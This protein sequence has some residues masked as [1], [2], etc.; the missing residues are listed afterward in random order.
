[1]VEPHRQDLTGGFF[2]QDFDVWARY[3][4]LMSPYWERF[5]ELLASG[6]YL[7]ILEP[8]FFAPLT[9]LRSVISN[10]KRT[11]AYVIK[12]R[13]PHLT[14][15][16]TCD[17]LLLRTAVKPSTDMI[18]MLATRLPELGYRCALAISATSL[19]ILNPIDPAT[20]TNVA[21]Y[22]SWMHYGLGKR[23]ALFTII[24]SAGLFLFLLVRSMLKDRQVLARILSDPFTAWELIFISSH[25][26]HAFEMMLNQMRPRLVVV[27]NERVPVAAELMLAAAR[28]RVHRVMYQNELPSI[29]LEPVLADEVWVWNATME[30][31]MRC[32]IEP[33]A[34][35]TVEI[36]GHGES[37]VALTTSREAF[38]SLE[39]DELQRLTSATV[40][41]PVI[42]FL[43]EYIPSKR[44]DFEASSRIACE[45]LALAAEHHPEWFFVLKTRPLQ[46]TLEI[47]GMEL[48]LNLENTYVSQHISLRILCQHD[49]IKIVSAL[50]STGLVT[51]LGLGKTTLRLWTSA[52]YG[53]I[54]VIDEFAYP[55]FSGTEL[56]SYLAEFRPTNTATDQQRLPY[57]KQ[58]LA[59]MTELTT[60]HLSINRSTPS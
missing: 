42:V 51:A 53:P 19:S 2:V 54:R 3:T 41:R 52:R 22:Q 24:R 6:F 16:L 27:N 56:S 14:T 48:L 46:P 28:H 7:S 59:R 36:V 31:E 30:Q 37:D 55:I 12:A 26:L 49:Q 58:V 11:I 25:R 23:Q 17:A 5:P 10:L 21:D 13:K 8:T 32:L 35:T 38:T 9:L 44:F 60:R 15:N 4:A 40:S 50:G 43:S 33:T 20:Q 57:R 18:A 1:M 45:W 47:P 34:R 29:M 39:A